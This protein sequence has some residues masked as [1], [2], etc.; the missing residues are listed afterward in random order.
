MPIRQVKTDRPACRSGSIRRRRLARYRQ[1]RPGRLK[2][3]IIRREVLCRL[4]DDQHLAAIRLDPARARVASCGKGAQLLVAR[5]PACQRVA[6]SVP[7]RTVPLQFGKW[8]L[9]L[10]LP[11]SGCADP[12]TK[13]D[14]SMTTSCSHGRIVSRAWKARSDHQGL[15]NSCPFRSGEIRCRESG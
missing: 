14:P 2:P 8:H 13:L 7:P 1:P 3:Q 4:P 12:S 11:E 6:L 5:R 9:H 15:V 10:P